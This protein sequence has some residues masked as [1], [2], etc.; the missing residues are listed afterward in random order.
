M[1]VVL[2]SKLF[3]ADGAVGSVIMVGK[4]HKRIAASKKEKYKKGNVKML[5]VL[6]E[7]AEK[8]DI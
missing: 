6:V 8:Y 1:V 4:I 7:K 5:V 2:Y 3:Y